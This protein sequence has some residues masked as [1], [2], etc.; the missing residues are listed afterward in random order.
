VQQEKI[1]Q[2]QSVLK[3]TLEQ[4]VILLEQTQWDPSAAIY[5][6]YSEVKFRI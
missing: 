6:F 1:H 2:V 5:K 4:A 3:V